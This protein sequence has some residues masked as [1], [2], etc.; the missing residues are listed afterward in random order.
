MNMAEFET[1]R[2]STLGELLDQCTPKERDPVSGRIRSY[3]VYRGAC[4]EEGRLLTALDRLGGIDPPHSKSHLEEHLLRN[5]IRYARP[6]LKHADDWEMVVSAQ[7]HGLPTRL[8]DWTYSPLIAAHFATL[9]SAPSSADRVIWKLDWR[10]LHEHL[11]LKP[12][13]FLVSDLDELLEQKGYRGAWDLFNA[14][15]DSEIFVCMFE[16]PALDQRIMAQGA[17]FTLTSNKALSFDQIIQQQKIPHCLSKIIIP[18]VCAEMVRD[19]LDMCNVDERH[20]FPGIDGVAAQLKRYY[21]ASGP[22]PEQPEFD[23]AKGPQTRARGRRRT[24]RNSQT[25]S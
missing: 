21:S 3:S 17:A 15:G 10:V 13:A 19:Q 6:F 4:C 8:L 9:N 16:P 14:K 1:C 12:L 22:D 23:Q 24:P 5:F 20:L 25:G 11:G 2:V 18:G 7:H